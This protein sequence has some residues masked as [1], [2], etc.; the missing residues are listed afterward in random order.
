MKEITKRKTKLE[1]KEQIV[2]REVIIWLKEEDIQKIEAI[3][4]A[5]MDRFRE[6]MKKRLCEVLG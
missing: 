2:E 1:K 6:R 5:R 4:K 3:V